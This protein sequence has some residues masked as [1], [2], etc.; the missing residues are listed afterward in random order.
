MG[1]VT[2]IIG[3]TS[4]FQSWVLQWVLVVLG[5]LVHYTG[6]RWQQEGS[7]YPEGNKNNKTKQQLKDLEA[8]KSKLDP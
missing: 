1:S 7:K 2:K 4:S 6:K 5:F 3:D 8:N